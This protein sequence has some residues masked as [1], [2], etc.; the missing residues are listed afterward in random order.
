VFLIKI[1]LNII[2]VLYYIKFELETSLT[3]WIGDQFE[4]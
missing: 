2:I 1:D 4:V 3:V